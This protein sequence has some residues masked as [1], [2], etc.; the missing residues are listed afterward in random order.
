MYEFF[1]KTLLAHP[2]EVE[3]TYLQHLVAA[4]RFALRLFLAAGA[5]LIHALVPCLFT[6]KASD[7]LHHLHDDMYSNRAAKL[8]AEKA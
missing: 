3:E 6:R 7:M 4:S 1:Y 5:C 8:D 2:A